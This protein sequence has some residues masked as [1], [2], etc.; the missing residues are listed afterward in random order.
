[1][2]IIDFNINS[3]SEIFAVFMDLRSTKNRNVPSSL[4]IQGIHK[5]M[6]RLRYWI[7]LKPHHYFVY[8][9]YIHCHSKATS[10]YRQVNLILPG[11][12]NKN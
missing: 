7:P 10:Q 8:T 1:M 11:K 5:R 3:L 4:Q 12:C 2:Y 9:L 6:V